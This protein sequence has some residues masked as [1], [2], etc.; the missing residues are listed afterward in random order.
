MSKK[1]TLHPDVDWRI[2]RDIR[3][4]QLEGLTAGHA[5]CLVCEYGWYAVLE[6]RADPATLKCTR[7]GANRSCFYEFRPVGQL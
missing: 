1:L 3:H 6:P 5:G 2:R 7:C 4:A